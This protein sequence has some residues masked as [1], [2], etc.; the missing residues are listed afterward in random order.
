MNSYA[1]LSAPEWNPFRRKFRV[2][3]FRV[4]RFN[5]PFST[6]NPACFAT[7]VPFMSRHLVSPK[8][9]GDGG[10]L[11]DGGVRQFNGTAFP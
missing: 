4:S 6:A 5:P 2:P 8:R 9:F 1:V 7:F 10:R 11:G 3:V